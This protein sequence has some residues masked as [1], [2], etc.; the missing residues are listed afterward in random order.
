MERAVET[1]DRR[2]ERLGQR[3]VDRVVDGPSL[4]MA[5]DLDDLQRSER[6]WM[7]SGTDSAKATAIASCSG[8]IRPL[9]RAFRSPL[10]T[11]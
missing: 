1:D 9:I 11:S 10:A 8:P 7:V 2:A 4:E 3:G 6:G 5:G